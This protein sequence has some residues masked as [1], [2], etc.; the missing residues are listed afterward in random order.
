MK[1]RQIAWIV[2]FVVEIFIVVRIDVSALA[3]AFADLRPAFAPLIVQHR[4]VLRRAVL[5]ALA[6]WFVWTVVEVPPLDEPANEGGSHSVLVILA[7]L[8]AVAYAVAAARYWT[9]YRGRLALLPASIIA[10]FILL[11]GARSIGDDAVQQ[12]D[13]SGAFFL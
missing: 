11:A 10:C 12:L 5:A 1:R 4:T 3:S 9:V 13:R 7:A 8:G 2:I 6:V